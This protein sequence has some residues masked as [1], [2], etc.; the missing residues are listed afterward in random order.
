MQALQPQLGSIRSCLLPTEECPRR[1]PSPETRPGRVDCL[2]CVP[3]P[4]GQGIILRVD[5]WTTRV[6]RDALQPHLI[7]GLSATDRTVTEAH[8]MPRDSTKQRRLPPLCPSSMRTGNNIERRSMDE[9]DR[10]VIEAHAKPRDST[11]QSRLPPL[12]PSS[13]KMDDRVKD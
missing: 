13:K 10:R 2:L 8:A 6:T 11:R 5:R 4:C 3:L 12:R 7:S 9:P 1:T